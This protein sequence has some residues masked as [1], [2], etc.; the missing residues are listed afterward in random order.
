[1]N[2][3]NTLIHPLDRCANCNL[4]IYNHKWPA[5]VHSHSCK[6][7][8]SVEMMCYLLLDLM[9]TN[10]I[11]ALKDSPTRV[12]REMMQPSIEKNHLIMLE[13]KKMLRRY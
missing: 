13:A 11:E 9:R 7:F 6:H 12:T 1:M 5:R 10:T 8:I 2:K 4:S 3:V